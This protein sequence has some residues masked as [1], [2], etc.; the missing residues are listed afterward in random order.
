MKQKTYSIFI[1]CFFVLFNFSFAQEYII[2]DGKNTN[3]IDAN[4]NRQGEWTIIDKKINL[5]L[6]TSFKDDVMSDTILFFQNK[7]LEFIWINLK[8]DSVKYLCNV[9]EKFCEGYFTKEN[10]EYCMDD[11]LVIKKIN[12][13]LGYELMPEYSEGETN[14]HRYIGRKVMDIYY[15]FERI[16]INANVIF[17]VNSKGFVSIVDVTNSL[18]PQINNEIKLVFKNMSRWFPGFGNGKFVDVKFTYP[19]KMVY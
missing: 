9:N 18:N 7:N 17:I 14:F 13:F 16:Q 4:G 3:R 10:I 6:K 5:E 8:N 19:L 15:K 2:Q 12:F 11:S 1:L